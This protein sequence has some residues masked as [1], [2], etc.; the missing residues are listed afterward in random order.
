MTPDEPLAP[1]RL[2]AFA[3]RI[4]V[5]AALLCLAIGSMVLTGYLQND[6]GL[7]NLLSGWIPMKPN[8][9]LCFIF[10][11]IALLCLQAP[12]ARSGIRRGTVLAIL[13]I[14][15]GLATLAEYASGKSLGIDSLLV[16][17]PYDQ[18]PPEQN[19]RMTIE[20]AVCQIFIGSALILN[21]IRRRRRSA[22]LT[23]TVLALI[24]LAVATAALGTYLSPLLGMLGWIGLPMMAADTALLLLVLSLAVFLVSCTRR[25]FSWMLSRRV[26]GAFIVGLVTLV[27]IFLTAL[28]SQYQVT[29][30][31]AQIENGESLFAKAAD[32]LAMASQ[33]HSLT[34]V[35]LVS[36]DLNHLNAALINADLTRI[37]LDEFDQYRQHHGDSET[38]QFLPIVTRAQAM[39]EWSS[40]ALDSHRRG[41]SAAESRALMRRGNALLA[42]MKLSFD[43][44]ESEH[45]HIVS[46]MRYKSDHVRRTAFLTIA[47]GMLGNLLVFSLVCL[48]LNRVM[49]EQHRIKNEL[50]ENEQRY[51]TL[52]NTG[53]ALIWTAGT[54]ALCNYFNSIWL[55][56]TGRTLEQELG[57]GWAEGVH[58]DDMQ[59]CLEIYLG[60]FEKRQKFSMDYR[61]RRHDGEYRWIQDEGSPRYDAQGNFIG[62]IG[63]CLDITDRKLATAAMEESEQRFRKLFGEIPSV[64]VQGYG[65]DL[66]THYWNRASERLYGYTAEEAIGRKLTDLII[67][68]EMRAAVHSAVSA[69][70]ASGQAN[71]TEELALMRKDGKPVNV[72]SS[73]AV[74][75]VPSKPPELFCVDIDI[76]ERKKVE[77]ELSQYR[78]H[79]ET[80]VEERTA[81]LENA[82]DAAE[83]ANRAKSSFLANMSHEIRTPMN[84]I[85]GFGHLLRRDLANTLA[86]T[87]G[88][89]NG[90]TP[91][92]NSAQ[93][94]V[95]KIMDAAQH[96]LGIINNILDLSKIEAGKLSLEKKLF[97]PAQTLANTLTM[98]DE[99]ANAKGLRILRAIHPNVPAEAIGDE[100]RVAQI[101]LNYLSNAIKFSEQGTIRVR[102]TVQHENIHSILLRLEVEDEGIGLTP[103]QRDSL[104]QAFVQADGSTTR[105]FGGTGLGLVISRHLARN[106]GGDVGVDSTPGVGSTFW[107][108]FRLGK[109][110]VAARPVA[111]SEHPK[112]AED[113]L[114][115]RF[116]GMRVLLVDDDPTGREIAT[117]L[118]SIAD[119]H[120][121]TACDGFDAVRKATQTAYP[122]ILMDMQM[123]GMSGIEAT[124]TIRRLSGESAKA[125]VLAMTANAFDE[126][127][128][129]CLNAGMNDHIA[130]PLD[131][132]VLYATLLKW[133]DWAAAELSRPR[134]Q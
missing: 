42:Q 24:V 90:G 82:L 11:A 46:E 29:A 6:P 80:L 115:Q 48:H 69:M 40:A 99:R 27:V 26:T 12:D 35:F 8:T 130:K 57:N 47:G 81:E 86:N 20:T 109:T 52:A 100:L 116:A 126:D 114:R 39:L 104:F 71:P 134:S 132:D 37:R 30:I 54:D 63:F 112:N 15:I 133:L 83:A 87:H 22:V 25:A 79:L 94:K 84:A 68:P 14:S 4:A 36:D 101:L 56:F 124:Q 62:Y 120:V 66:V 127:R 122:L 77:A 10:N 105:R 34:L 123:P 91:G 38:W 129:D 17:W 88:N 96:L 95:D 53:Q 32:T 16:Q 67:P 21:V 85:I 70:M 125:I 7:K 107:A 78:E 44:T 50:I 119:F 64:A 108:T 73:H 1:D 2:S 23:A 51:R 103:E 43:Q 59:R 9:A 89:A 41:I 5:F 92:D 97:S 117:E 106:M 55:E 18:L 65:P 121:D 118:L 128:R 13:P 113:I 33:Q 98:V 110:T 19:Y 49:A 102:L 74:V 61:L 31:N 3:A 72:I 131:A 93:A 76:S 58:P 60:A 75:T 111:A 28:R 45:R